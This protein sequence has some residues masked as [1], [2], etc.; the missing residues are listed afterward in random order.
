MQS[1]KWQFKVLSFLI[2][3]LTFNFALL[4]FPPAASAH[5]F[6]KLYNLPV[7]FWIY[8]YGGAAAVIA[9][10][11]VIGYFINRTRSN[12]SF[13]AKDLSKISMFSFFISRKFLNVL[14][15][16]SAF[17][18]FL[19]IIT[20]LI[21]EDNPY[22]NFNMTFFWIIF[23]LGLTYLT[24]I[25]GNIYSI[26]NPWK[27][28]VEWFESLSGEKIQ[29]FVK[30]P[31]KLAYWPSLTFYFLFIWIELLAQTTPS[32]LSFLL[33]QYTLISI[34]GIAII[35]KNN[36]FMYGDFFS[37]FFRLISKISP[38]E[39]REDKLYL[40]P[41][42]V[43]L[44]K[45]KAEHFSLLLFILF[46]L[47]STAF[48]GFRETVPWYRLYWQNLSDI[49]PHQ[50]FQTIGLALSPFVFL[51]I[52]LVFIALAKFL[53][54]STLS[55]R[56]LSLRFAYSLVPIAFVYNA[57]HYYTLL[58][59]QGQEIIRLASDPFG[60]GWNSFG[61]SDYTANLSIIDANITWHTQ[62]ALILIGHIAGVYLAHIIALNIFPS[63]KKALTSQLPMLTLMVTYTMIGLWI[64][65][66]PITSG[67]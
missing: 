14:K 47:S 11:I 36:W 29:G 37:I 6:G 23:V 53:A 7:P 62:V 18:F 25:I 54:K 3:L 39:R 63:H 19:T 48:D 42:F 35:G 9:S 1:S 61:T 40:R 8:L 50:L 52:Y 30:Y 66:Q 58:L 65:S 13:P 21:G 46:M 60:F 34:A 59:T 10:F 57:A 44:L 12:L 38:I 64:L 27:V 22:S 49:V 32:A 4:S 67:L 43:G 2:P 56:E 17:L 24:S 28:L 16:I 26:I 51:V 45:E 41:P 55:V 5:A 15:I 33:I 31:K 20:G